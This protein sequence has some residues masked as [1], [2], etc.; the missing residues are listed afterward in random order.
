M[1]EGSPSGLQS[2]FNKNANPRPC[3]DARPDKIIRDKKPHKARFYPKTYQGE[4]KKIRDQIKELKAEGKLEGAALDDLLAR[5]DDLLRQWHLTAKVEKTIQNM[6][7]V[8]KE[9]FYAMKDMQLRNH[10]L[11]P[12]SPPPITTH[13]A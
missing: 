9:L 8:M 1:V 10:S 4:L 7:P 2:H 11:D 3:D 6:D 5:H 12:K 13:Q